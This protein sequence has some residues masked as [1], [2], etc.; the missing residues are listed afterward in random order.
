[1]KKTLSEKIEKIL[2]AYAISMIDA[3]ECYNF[4]KSNE[5]GESDQYKNSTW[6]NNLCFSGDWIGF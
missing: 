5:F 1:M 2:Y 3:R 4:D 6:D